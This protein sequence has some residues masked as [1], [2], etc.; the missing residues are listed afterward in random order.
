MVEQLEVQHTGDSRDPAGQQ[1][2]G[3]D[4]AERPGVH[5]TGEGADPR[6]G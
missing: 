6:E 1:Q 3:G 4:H 5:R 2:P